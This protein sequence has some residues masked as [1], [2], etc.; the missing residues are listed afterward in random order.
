MN[1]RK[2][3]PASAK[4]LGIY[5]WLGRLARDFFKK[6][7]GGPPV[8]REKSPASKRMCLVCACAC[9]LAGCVEPS[10]RNEVVED[11]EG[12]VKVTHVEKPAAPSHPSP[13]ISG[14]TTSNASSV[15]AGATVD[16]RIDA[17]EEQSRQ[18]NEEITKLKLQ[19]AAEGK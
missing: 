5:S 8:P 4:S 10:Y 16:Q 11:G 9:A 3:A 19:R 15:P 13:L 6:N 12:H 14:T 18:L 2:H 17:L 1:R 7:T